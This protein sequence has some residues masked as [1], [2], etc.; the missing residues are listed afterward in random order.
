MVWNRNSSVGIVTD[1]GMEEALS[2][3]LKRQEREAEHSLPSSAE[4]KNVGAI[5]PLPYVPS[6]HGA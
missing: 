3:G 5:P 4:V 2:P 6:W 1:Y